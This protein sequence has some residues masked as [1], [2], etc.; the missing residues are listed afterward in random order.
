MVTTVEAHM[1]LALTAP[2]HMDLV[3]IAPALITAHTVVLDHITITTPT[4][5]E[6]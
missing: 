3:P 6:I 4:K 5:A 2:A 1:D